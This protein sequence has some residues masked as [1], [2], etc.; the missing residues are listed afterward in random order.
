[1]KL[2]QKEVKDGIRQWTFDGGC[3][4]WVKFCNLI[5]KNKNIQQ[6][7]AYLNSQLTQDEIAELKK[8]I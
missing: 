6:N 3:D 2:T 1:M 4:A 5:S 7:T 8:I